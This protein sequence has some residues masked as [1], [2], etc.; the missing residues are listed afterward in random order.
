MSSGHPVD[1][2]CCRF[3]LA[4]RRSDVH[5]H[6]ARFDCHAAGVQ[7]HAVARLAG[8]APGRATRRLM[9][10]PS[11]TVRTDASHLDLD[12]RPAAG[13][14]LAGAGGYQ[15]VQR[16]DGPAALCARGD[17]AAQWHG[18]SPRQGQGRGLHARMGGEALRVD[19]GPAFPP[20]AGVHE[21]TVPPL[22]A[23]V[24]SRV[25][26][27]GRS[28]GKLRARMGAAQLW[29]A[30]CSA[31]DSPSRRATRS[32]SASLEAVAFAKGER[33]DPFDSAAPEL[34]A[35][36]R[37]RAASLAARDRPQPLRQRPRRTPRRDGAFTA[38]RPISRI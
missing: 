2:R 9:S 17:A 18:P 25:R 16:G 38:W 7:R 23:G 5:R 12:I 6:C 26:R 30:G 15:P 36:A 24:R 32:A 37:E 13:S 29:S 3:H 14:A 8:I 22:R 20:V 19:R 4:G 34:P 35:G 1:H 11:P 28:A 21:G 33:D 10:R 31:H 27:Q